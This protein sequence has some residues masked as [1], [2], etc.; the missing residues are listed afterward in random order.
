MHEPENETPTLTPEQQA[1]S[2]EIGEAM[3]RGVRNMIDRLFPLRDVP[4]PREKKRK[5]RGSKTRATKAKP[6][7][8][9]STTRRT[10]SR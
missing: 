5:T 10:G 2:D 1:L 9:T 4:D 7:P 3:H 6:K 8:T